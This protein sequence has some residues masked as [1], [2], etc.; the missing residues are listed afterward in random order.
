VKQPF[1]ELRANGILELS[2]CHS[3]LIIHNAAI[4]SRRTPL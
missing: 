1:D 3:T 2:K 4:A